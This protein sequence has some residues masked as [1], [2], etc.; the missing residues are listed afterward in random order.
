M[1]KCVLETYY[2]YCFV[3]LIPSYPV[4]HSIS[5]SSSQGKEFSYSEMDLR[6]PKRFAT[7]S[8]GLR[9]RK[10]NDQA[11]ISKSTYGLH[12]AGIEE[13]KEV[14]LAGL[15]FGPW[16]PGFITPNLQLRF[17]FTELYAGF[18]SLFSSRATTAVFAG[19]ISS[20]CE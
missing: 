20:C 12:G 19:M 16:L 10:K 8:F 5:P 18:S 6:K 7:F 15:S 11:S 1:D 9:K 17:G 4:S 2:A 3:F 14:T 13:Q